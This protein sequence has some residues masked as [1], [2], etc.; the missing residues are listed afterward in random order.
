MNINELKELLTEL[1]EKDLADGA[2]IFDHPG[3]VAVRAIDRMVADI[4]TLKEIASKRKGS[5][6]AQMLTGLSYNPSF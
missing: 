4:D 6:R 5:K 3:I 1:A 2:D